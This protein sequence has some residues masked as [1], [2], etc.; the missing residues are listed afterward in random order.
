MHKSIL[1]MTQQYAKYCLF[2]HYLFKKSRHIV[3]SPAMRVV[4]GGFDP[5]V[6][7]K[8]KIFEY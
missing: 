1:I 6:F 4:I 2:Y 3:F 8:I 7:D 5:R